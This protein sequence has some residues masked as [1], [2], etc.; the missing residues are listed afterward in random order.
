MQEIHIQFLDGEDPLEEEITTHSSVLAWKIPWTEVPSGWATVHEVAK[1]QTWLSNWT[2]WAQYSTVY[3]PHFPYP[4]IFC[5]TLRLLPFLE[6]VNNAAMNIGRHASFPISVCGFSGYTPKWKSLSHVHFFA[7]PWT[8]QSIELGS[9]SL[10]Q[11]IFPNQGSNQVSCIAGRFF[12]SWD[13]REA[14]TPKFSSVQSL[15]YVWP[16][17]TPWTLNFMFVIGD[18]FFFFL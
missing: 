3:I 9:H 4:F 7:I 1:S 17:A 13:T 12:T 14:H 2:Q 6:I 18:Q 15:S 10:L 16:F 11:G 8:I 5:W